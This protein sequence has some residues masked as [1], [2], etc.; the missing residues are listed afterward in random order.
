MLTAQDEPYGGLVREALDAAGLP[1]QATVGQPLSST[2]LARSF[3]DLLALPERRF[4][5]DAVLEWLGGRPPIDE[6]ADDPLLCVPRS[7][8]ERIS[9]DAGVVEDVEQWAR[10]CQ[11]YAA[12]EL[13]QARR[14]HEVPSSATQAQ[15]I[16][17]IVA[18]LERETRPPADG[19]SWGEFV[20][21]AQGLR[22]RYLPPAEAWSVA[23][24]RR[25]GGTRPG[26]RQP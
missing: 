26:T 15:R 2:R 4:A 12:R 5:R 9:R 1:W 25:R 14:G 22:S 3:L 11:S 18:E 6:P 13:A 16:A 17:E 19:A 24:A 23:G 8:W 7:A 10:R 20:A 21:W